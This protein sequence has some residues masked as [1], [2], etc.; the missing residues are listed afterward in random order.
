MIITTSISGDQKRPDKCSLVSANSDVTSPDGSLE[1][2]ALGL[3]RDK[4]N[5]DKC[6]LANVVCS[7]FRV[8]QP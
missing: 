6:F 5:L 3:E 2:S 7:L 1:D 4:T 8:F